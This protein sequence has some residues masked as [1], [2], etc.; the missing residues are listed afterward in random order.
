[1]GKRKSRIGRLPKYY[2][3]KRQALHKNPIGRPCKFRRHPAKK[4]NIDILLDI[5][6]LFIVLNVGHLAWL[7]YMYHKI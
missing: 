5:Q 4:V 7:T 3:K 2:E 6:V 1:M